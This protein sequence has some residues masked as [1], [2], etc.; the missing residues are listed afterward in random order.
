MTWT[1]AFGPYHGSLIAVGQQQAVLLQ[2]DDHEAAAC[3]PAGRSR[4]DMADQ[5]PGRPVVHTAPSCPAPYRLVIISGS[6]SVTRIVCSKWAD[7]DRSR[8][9]TVQPSALVTT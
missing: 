1:L 3:L 7:R 4:Y 5:K 8:V 6:P 2:T 9:A